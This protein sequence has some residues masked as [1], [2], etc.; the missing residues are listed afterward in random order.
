MQKVLEAYQLIRLSEIIH[1][2]T[3]DLIAYNTSQ[4]QD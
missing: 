4:S 1:D 3:E 2:N